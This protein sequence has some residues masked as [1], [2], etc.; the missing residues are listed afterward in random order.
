MKRAI[1]LISGLL[2]CQASVLQAQKKDT[3]K[4]EVIIISEF[5]PTISDARKLSKEP[6][7]KQ[8]ESPKI[9]FQYDVDPVF[10]ENEFTADTIKAAKIKSEGLRRLYKSYVRLGAGNYSST[11]ADLYINNTRSKDTWWGGGF[12]HRASAGDNVQEYTNR[13]SSQNANAYYKKIWK[14]HF[15]IAD[16]NY[17]RDQVYYY[18]IDSLS[19]PLYRELM[20]Q[21]S[22]QQTFQTFGAKAE[23][24]S[25]FADSSQVNY[26][27]KLNFKH[28][29]NADEFTESRVLLSTQW[30]QYFGDQQGLLFFDVD[31]NSPTSNFEGTSFQPAVPDGMYKQNILVRLE[32][33]VI[34]EGEKFKLDAGLGMWLENESE[35]TFRF[36]PKAEFKYNVIGNI[37]IPYVGVTGGL[38]RVNYNSLR[39]ENPW[40][41]QNIEINNQ[42]NRYDAY[43]GVRGTYSSTISF[44]IKAGRQQYANY[45]LFVNS[46]LFDPL[47]LP[48]EINTSNQFDVVYDTMNI[49]HVLVEMAYHKM[50]KWNLTWR[51]DY[52]SYDPSNEIK[53][54]NLP[55]FTSTLTF[56]YDLQDKLVLTT[57]L[58]FVSDRYVKELNANEGE[59]LAFG[60]YG[61]KLPSYIDINLG[62]EY[63]YN[64]KIAAFVQLNN[65]ANQRYQMF[66]DYEVQGINIMA[67]FSYSFLGD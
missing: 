43:V 57:D 29:W 37:V 27:I 41:S 2:L 14:S 45:H 61:T 18:G 33:H 42:N 46:P 60:V 54:W 9:D 21:D 7:I 4:T 67:G 12:H 11:L 58:F 38:E 36:Y 66:K 40:I 8:V 63:R 48:V 17:S 10:V 23:Y 13:F 30:D 51:N 32:P 16:L 47:S 62:L 53:A 35:T 19:A 6:E 56:R 15:G 3:L 34:A 39:T 65:I 31:V 5:E 52:R 28:L 1:V 22:L 50:E 49:R 55:N 26:H 59:E 24:R 64:R 25:F 44:N 20:N